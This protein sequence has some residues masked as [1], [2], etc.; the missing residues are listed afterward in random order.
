MRQQ[1]RSNL[2][3]GLMTTSL[4]PEDLRR[5]LQ[6]GECFLLLSI[7]SV[8]GRREHSLPGSVVVPFTTTGFSERVRA[9]VASLQTPVILYDDGS[10][11]LQ[12]AEAAAQL[13]S[14]GFTEVWSYCGDRSYLTGP[15][16]RDSFR[17]K[18]V[19]FRA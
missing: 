2:Q 4:S 18:E 1:S 16:L 19:A 7:G 8:T 13:R 17:D 11:C 5:V 3:E 6:S 15:P 14:A 12:M 9:E 10:E